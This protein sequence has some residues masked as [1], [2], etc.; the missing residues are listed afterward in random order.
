MNGKLSLPGTLGVRHKPAEGDILKPLRF[1]LLSSKLNEQQTRCLYSPA[2]PV[3]TGVGGTVAHGALQSGM[4]KDA[5][6][7]PRAPSRQRADI[8]LKKCCFT[9]SESAKPASCSYPCAPQLSALL[10]MSQA[11]QQPL[12]DMSRT[13]ERVVHQLRSLPPRQ[14]RSTKEDITFEKRTIAG[15]SEVY[16]KTVLR[17]SV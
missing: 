8:V 11:S 7:H 16:L 17:S 1:R 4:W 14:K 13:K 2:S 6:S 9:M 15:V 10:P 5:A 3:Y 12:A